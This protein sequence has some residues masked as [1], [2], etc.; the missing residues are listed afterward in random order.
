MSTTPADVKVG[1][2]VLSLM[3]GLSDKAF[4]WAA[5]VMSFSLTCYA[6]ARP[7]VWRFSAVAVFVALVS[8]LWLRKNPLL[9]PS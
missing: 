1:H 3:R 4:R 5:L 8:P 9:G 2:V 6:V 7:D